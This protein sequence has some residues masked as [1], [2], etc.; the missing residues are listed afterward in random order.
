MYAFVLA[1]LL[2]MTACASPGDTPPN[3][4]A[5]EGASPAAAPAGQDSLIQARVGEELVITLQSN[6]S[7]GYRWMLEDSL[8]AGLLR[9]AGR[10]YVPDQP[11][12]VGSG[13]HE[14]FTFVGVAPGET[15][16]RLR[17]SRDIQRS[18]PGRAAFRVRIHPAQ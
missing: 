3:V 12:R 16:L 17:Y 6:P 4:P 14:Q 11:V 18:A 1:L 13:G 15:T 5:Q 10:T 2:L 7:T 9:L 8:D